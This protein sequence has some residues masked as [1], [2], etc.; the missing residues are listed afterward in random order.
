MDKFWKILEQS[1]IVSGLI[2]L[3]LVGTACYLALTGQPIPDYLGIA[4]GT[5]VGFFFGAKV[6]RTAIQARG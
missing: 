1:V 3:A 5:V 2:A 4:L 6:E